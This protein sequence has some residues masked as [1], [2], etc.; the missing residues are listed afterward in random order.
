MMQTSSMIMCLRACLMQSAL[1]L[2]A[3]VAL[4]A[5]P[6][7]VDDQSELDYLYFKERV[8]PIL[9]ETR[10]GQER[11][12][13][14]HPSDSSLL[15]E[16]PPG[17]TTWTNDRS[18]RHFE[19]WRELVVPG[20]PMDSPLLTQPL[21]TEAG[22]SAFHTGGKRWASRADGEWLTL[23]AWVRGQRLGGLA[24]PWSPGFDR[25]LQANPDGD[26]VLVVDPAI[27]EVV[28]SIEDIAAPGGVAIAADGRRV[29]VTNRARRTLDVVDVRTLEVFK[30][31]D[32][33][34]VPSDVD[35]AEDGERIY[36][37]LRGD[38][39]GVDVIDARALTRTHHIPV[40]GSVESVRL[41]PDGTHLFVGTPETPVLQ[42]IDVV[43]HDAVTWR[44]ALDAGVET[45]GFVKRGDGSTRYIVVQLRG[46]HGFT[47]ID[48][49]TR[50]VVERVA[51][52]GTPSGKASSYGLALDPSQTTL[53]IASSHDDSVVAYGVPS[54][55][56]RPGQAGQDCAWERL[57]SVGVGRRP[58]WLTVTP[59]GQTLYV[60]LTGEKAAALVNT[61]TMAMV[62]K[63][64]T[65][66]GPGRNVAG[67]LAT[68]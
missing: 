68:R 14:C 25:V 11:C 15:G 64:S 63:L 29:Y 67:T 40:D 49:G 60:S 10:V 21:A 62:G 65:G 19:I 22:G 28:G 24:T 35:R 51:P 50:R 20:R 43:S 16:L 45:M 5:Q 42:G 56:C 58:G 66:N 41:A 52:P 37:G 2:A 47:V 55:R 38:I 4:F 17:E 9:V 33:S 61:A 1:V 3:G 18:R 54:R 32:L 57:E 34:G 12:V 31:I 6:P 39:G 23:A 36:V 53:W 26:R 13:T 44:V 46:Q 48:F 8:Q 7:T 30:R 27:P 59:D